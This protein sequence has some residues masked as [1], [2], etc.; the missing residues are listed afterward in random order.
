MINKRPSD[1][2]STFRLRRRTPGSFVMVP[3]PKIGRSLRCQGQLERALAVVLAGCP[4]VT[5]I[6]EQPMKVW[7][8]WH[9]TRQGTTIRLLEQEPKTRHNRATGE[10]FSYVVPDFLISPMNGRSRLI[11]VKPSGKLDQDVIQRKLAVSATFA[12]SRRWSFHVITE[13]ELFSTPL[14]R[15]LSFVARYLVFDADD[16]I[17]TQVLNLIPS[18]GIQIGE[19]VLGLPPEPLVVKRHILH[20]LAAGEIS[21]DPVIEPFTD[22]VLVFPKGVISWDPFDSLWVSSS[23][24]MDGPIKWSANSPTTA[25]LLKTQRSA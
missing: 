5:D 22:N 13:Q 24:S 2:C 11:E 17:S 8:G 18:A 25:L 7:Y 21:F 15:N 10:R 4:S 19:L 12:A 16:A 20:L 9:D 23:Y 1:I 6:E 3:C 14:V